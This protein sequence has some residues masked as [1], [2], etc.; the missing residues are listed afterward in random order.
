MNL[1]GDQLYSREFG[2]QDIWTILV[3]RRFWIFTSVAIFFLLSIAYA[4]LKTPIYRSTVVMAYVNPDENSSMA[5]SMLGQLSGLAALAG[6]NLSGSGSGGRHEA[7]ATFRSRLFTE[8]FIQK[9]G[10]MSALFDSEWDIEQ[11]TWKSDS[12]SEPPTLAD[13][14]LRFTES[15][16]SIGEDPVTGLITL[17]VEWKDPEL[18]GYWANLLVSEINELLKM[19]AIDEARRSIGYLNDELAKT[20]VVELQMAIYRLIEAQIQRVMLANVREAYAFKVL[21]P[22]FTADQDEFVKPNRPVVM[23]VGVL[24]GLLFG[25]ALAFFV[26][27]VRSSSDMH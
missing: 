1:P 23:I 9:H 12:Q 6:L 21:D 20:T 13:A 24:F 16:R 10:L 19:Q 11:G 14:H 18:A 26:N 17:K 7:L 27:V 4:F 5:S 22:A 8:K 25:I 2:L 3:R 15:V